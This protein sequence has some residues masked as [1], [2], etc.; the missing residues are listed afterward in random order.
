MSVKETVVKNKFQGGFSDEV[1]NST[2]FQNYTKRAEFCFGYI[3]SGSRTDKR[4]QKIEEYLR[5]VQDLGNEGI[6][7]W[8]TST[9]GR[10]MMDQVDKNTSMK[11]FMEIVQAYCAEA[12]IQV[13]IWSH[14]DHLGSLSDTMKITESIKKHAKKLR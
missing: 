9:C 2:I 13:T 8:L 1:E 6:S 3:G 12:F 5:N 11:R 7:T 10:H 4:D 14:P